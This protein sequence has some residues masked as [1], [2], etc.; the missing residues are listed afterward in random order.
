MARFQKSGPPRVP[1]EF[2]ATTPPV[3]VI[4]STTHRAGRTVPT[5]RVDEFHIY[6]FRTVPE[7]TKTCFGCRDPLGGIVCAARCYAYMPISAPTFVV[8]TRMF[9]HEDARAQ[10]NAYF[11]LDPICIKKQKAFHPTMLTVPDFTAREVNTIEK[12]LLMQEAELI[13]FSAPL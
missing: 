8:V 1:S 10:Q 9:R 3:A 4:Q 7:Q 11:H 5:P 2:L 13:G 6:L 12:E